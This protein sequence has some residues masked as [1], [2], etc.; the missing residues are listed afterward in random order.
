LEAGLRRGLPEEVEVLIDQ[1]RGERRAPDQRRLGEAEHVERGFDPSPRILER[2]RIR[3]QDGR[4]ISEHRATQVPV[5]P[6]GLL[7]RRARPEADRLLFVER[8]ELGSEYHEEVSAARLITRIQGGERDALAD[9]YG[10]Y[11]DRVYS[12]LR[13]MSSAGEAEK[14][15]EIGLLSAFGQLGAYEFGHGPFRTWLFATLQE[16]LA[17]SLPRDLEAGTRPAEGVA[18]IERSDGDDGRVATI[19]HGL[20]DRDLMALLRCLPQAERQVVALRFLVG[21]RSVD[22]AEVVGVSGD[23]VRWIQ[24]MALA[25]L[26]ERLDA[27]GHQPQPTTR[28]VRI[29]MRRASRQAPVLRA[30][31]LA[32][33]F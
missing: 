32:L 19:L 9:L 2:R 7:P 20:D 10:L 25:L 15:S 28:A 3:N 4:R 33:T 27:L 13:L 23:S 30:R 26:R 24:N 1:R 16:R 17:D 14:L 29:P 18:A 22:V 8:L 5:G 31:R 6:P 12:Y 21:L 11:F